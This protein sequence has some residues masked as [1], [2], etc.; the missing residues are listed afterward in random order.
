MSCPIYKTSGG[1][2]IGGLDP[3]LV[4]KAV[5]SEPKT[6]EIP[7]EDKTPVSIKEEAKVVKKTTKKPTKKTTTKKR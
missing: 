4:G 7:L 1:L 3:D 6:E 5:I 2:Q